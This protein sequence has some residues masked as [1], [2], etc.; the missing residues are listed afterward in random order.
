MT[1]KYANDQVDTFPGYGG[2]EENEESDGMMTY[3]KL[4]ENFCGRR[5]KTEQFRANLWEACA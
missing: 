1:L 4:L 5:Q 3:R 2:V